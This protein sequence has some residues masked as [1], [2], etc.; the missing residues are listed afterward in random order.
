MRPS[1]ARFTGASGGGPEGGRAFEGSAGR[2]CRLPLHAGGHA[3]QQGRL[4]HH[5]E[6]RTEQVGGVRLHEKEEEGAFKGFAPAV[7]SMC[8]S[9]PPRFT[10]DTR[11]VFAEVFSLS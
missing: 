6:P 8:L 3:P 9:P 10:L 7:M 11:A 2:C 1:S 4:V 5:A